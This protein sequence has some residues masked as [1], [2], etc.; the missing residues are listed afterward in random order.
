MS[1]V[2]R[3]AGGCLYALVSVASV[4]N[5][6]G[7][8]T[9]Q[10]GLTNEYKDVSALA[11][12]AKESGSNVVYKDCTPIRLDI[13]LYKG[14]YMLLNTVYGYE[15]LR[16]NDCYMMGTVILPAAAKDFMPGGPDVTQCTDARLMLHRGSLFVIGPGSRDDVTVTLD[17]GS[18]VRT[19]VRPKAFS[20]AMGDTCAVLVTHWQITHPSAKIIDA[21]YA[22]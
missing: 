22:E 9:V 18:R 16:H 3:I 17:D 6:T 8:I 12:C 14:S 21:V 10:R 7:A 11:A 13:D 2:R 19:R 1:R 20:D 15:R 4:V 5:L